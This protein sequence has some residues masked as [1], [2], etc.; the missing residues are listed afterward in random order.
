VVYA[1]PDF[2]QIERLA[3]EVPG[4]GL[5]R[6]Q[7]VPRLRGDDQHRKVALRIVGLQRR[8]HLESVH[9]RHLQVEQDQVVVVFSVQG[10]NLVRIGRRGDAGI[11]RFAQGLL[12]QADV[13]LLIVHDQDAGRGNL[14]VG[15]DHTCS[16]SAAPAFGIL[17][18]ASS[19]SM[20]SLTLMGLVR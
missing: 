18:A 7:L 19:A 9:P 11:T 20:N 13:R 17:S 6:S 10:A 4:A 16:C 12:Q 15:R 2:D 5:Q 14:P 8:H 3:H 1:R